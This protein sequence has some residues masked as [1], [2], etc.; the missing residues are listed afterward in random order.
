MQGKFKN[1]ALLKDLFP[2]LWIKDEK[3]RSLFLISFGLV[4]ISI[5]L[6]LSIP[7]ILKAIVAL[8]S[9]C[10][11]SM[12]YQ[13]SLLLV[14]YGVIWTASQIILQAR[15]ILMIK[16][17]EKCI[18]L[19]CSKLFDHLHSLPLKF[20]LDRK[21]GAITN[22][23]ERAQHGFPD[24]FW[25]LFLFAIPTV[26][27]LFL[28]AMILYYYY[29]IIYAFILIF[30]GAIFVIFTLYAVE[31]A[32][33]FQT[34]SNEQQSSANATIV[35]SLLNIISVKY[36]NNKE[37]EVTKCERELKKRE[38][39]LIKSLSSIE[40]IR[41]GQSVII[42]F[43]LILFTYAAG[44]QTL[45]SIYDVSDFVLINGYV[46]QFVTPL[47]QIGFIA[48]NF[49]SGMNELASVMEIFKENPLSVTLSSPEKDHTLGTL[50]CIEFQN[51]V[52]GY[53]PSRFV[54]QD[55]SFRLEEG[56][57]LGIVG[58]TGSG[59]STISYLLLKFYEIS[60]G[61]IFINNMDIQNVR[62]ESLSH[63]IGVIP[64]DITLFNTTIYENVLFA[65]PNA[66]KKDVEEAIELACLAPVL[67]RLPH[68]YNTIVGER[69]LK[70]SGGEKQRIAIARVL[71]KKPSLYI[72]DEAT[73]SLDLATEKKIMK[74]IAHTLK[75]STSIIIA[76]RLSTIINADEILVFHYG[77]IIE[78][79]THSSLLKQQGVYANLWEAHGQAHKKSYA[80]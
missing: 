40:L 21:T 44:Q 49:R 26:I 48:R 63:L 27:E 30:T 53:T 59:K 24:V 2:F 70:L 78:R 77:G 36:F 58:T 68:H 29:G 76:H 65:R 75:K 71:L 55:I 73:S 32:S 50:H 61:K 31:W 45:S 13:L 38:K 33:Y 23:L 12:T 6:D 66:S 25:G 28:A 15:Q 39:L 4:F 46:L 67:K 80:A 17:L 35:D 22:A 18:R 10:D 52:F 41:I 47:S 42:G 19:F 43:G 3:V 56:K 62:I 64:Q 11:K 54:L 69:G 51:V 34:L 14:A 5:G 7:L 72:F 74:N 57:T 8:L 1:I 16:P 37:Y 20:H 60:S 9:A 79:G